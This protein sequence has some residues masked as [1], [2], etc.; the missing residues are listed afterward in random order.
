M[1]TTIDLINAIEAGQSIKIHSIFEE[2]INSRLSAAIDQ[3]RSEIADFV[4]NGVNE[5]EELDED[6]VNEMDQHDIGDILEFMMSEEFGSIDELSKTTL[7][8]Y[9]KKASANSVHQK[10]KQGA[11]D[12][13]LRQQL[14]SADFRGVEDSANRIRKISTVI[15]KRNTGID[16]AVDRLVK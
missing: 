12:A 3:R 10:A 7:G 4:F 5:S 1:T 6:F 9:V 14:R 15:K 13:H 16:K 2:L 8:N 11:L